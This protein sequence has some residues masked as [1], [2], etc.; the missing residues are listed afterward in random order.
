MSFVHGASDAELISAYRSASVL[1]NPSR[2]EGFGLPMVEAM[3]C[4]TP[5]ICTDGGSQ[6]EVAGGAAEIVPVG[7]EHA[8]VAAMRRVLFDEDRRAELS[9]LGLAR[10]AQF[11]WDATAA[12][13]LALYREALGE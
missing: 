1:V 13:T 7:D 10:A 6:P 8:L 4:G 3:K 12:K 5:V 9:R 11:S 2:Y